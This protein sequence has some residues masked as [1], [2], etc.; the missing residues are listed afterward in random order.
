MSTA[1]HIFEFTAQTVKPNYFQHE[2]QYQCC[3]MYLYSLA[4]ELQADFKN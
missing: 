3:T 2:F 4:L 1:T